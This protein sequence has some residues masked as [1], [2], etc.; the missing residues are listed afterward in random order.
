MPSRQ[1]HLSI[2][3]HSSWL[4]FN[5]GAGVEGETRGISLLTK[6]R[7]YVQH[8]AHLVSYGGS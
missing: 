7:L 2:Q 4:P 6:S 3:S 5:I 8:E 1:F